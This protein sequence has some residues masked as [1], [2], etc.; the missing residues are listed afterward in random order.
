MPVEQISPKQLKIEMQQQEPPLILDVRE[1]F[2]FQI[3]NVQP[4]LHIPMG[5]LQQRIVDL[6]KT[7]AVVVLCHHG[8][9]SQ[10]V[11]D[12]LAYLGFSSVFNLTGGIDAWS[13]QCDATVPRY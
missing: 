2:E 5:E 11:A 8:I 1:P 6:N 9:R 13:S 10:Q 3:A 7:Q 4:S 12:Y